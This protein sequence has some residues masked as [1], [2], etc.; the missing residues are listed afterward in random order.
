VLD[1]ERA[2]L[3]ALEMEFPTAALSGC[4]FHLNQSLWRHV[5]ELGLAT[6]YHRDYHLQN[7]VQKIMAIGFLPV[8]LVWQNF[9]MF[10]NGRFIR[11]MVRRYPPLDD[12][13]E[14]DVTTYIINNARFPPPMRNVFKRTT[15]TRTNNHLE[16]RPTTRL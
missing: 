5:Q 7:A 1:F 12:W 9:L 15:D 8:P 6:P 2:L 10:H 16:G 4:Y 3:T 11:R 13:L 14:Y